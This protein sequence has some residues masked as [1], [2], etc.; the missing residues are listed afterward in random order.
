MKTR[1]AIRGFL[2]KAL[3]FLTVLGVEDP[4]AALEQLGEEHAMM[5]AAGK[6]DMVEI[7]FLDEPNVNERFLRFGLNPT[8]MVMPIPIDLRSKG[9]E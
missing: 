2:G 4:D 8:G 9:G 5:M 1:L 7:E 3:Q 6:I